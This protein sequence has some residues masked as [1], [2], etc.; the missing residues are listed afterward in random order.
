MIDHFIF[1]FDGTISDS[2]PI[3][4]QIFHEIA[5]KHK[6]PFHTSDRELDRMLKINIK[7]GFEFLGWDK[8]YEWNFFLD[9]FHTYQANHALDFQAFPEAEELLKRISANGKKSYLYTHSGAI[10]KVMLENMGLLH[11]FDFILDS[12]YG[13][14]AKPK[15]D[16]L[17]FFLKKFGMEPLS[18]MMIGDRPID[19]QA[20]MNAGMVG[21]LWD[22]D[23]RYSDFCADVTVQS[24][25][26][27]GIK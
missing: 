20:G 3:F 10:V 12:S 5:Q 26:D 18:C 22:V 6:L 19:A 2:Y 7:R 8:V 14:P 21:C 25:L 27:I 9:E 1:D 23:G 13:F 16:A 17:L 15:P 4:I 11:Y 24:L